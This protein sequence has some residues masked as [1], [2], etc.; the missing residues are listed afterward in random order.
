MQDH[1]RRIGRL[2]GIAEQIDRRLDSLERTIAEQ[3]REVRGQIR[4]LTGLLF[5]VL[6]LQVTILLKMLDS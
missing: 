1:D 3:F 4:W 2:E 6:G 5:A